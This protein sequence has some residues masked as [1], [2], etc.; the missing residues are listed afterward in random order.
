MV[1]NER[2]KVYLSFYKML[3]LILG[4]LFL[5]DKI[6]L[7]CLDKSHNKLTFSLWIPNRNRPFYSQQSWPNTGKICIGPALL[8]VY[9]PVLPSR[10]LWRGSSKNSLENTLCLKGYITRVVFKD[11]ICYLIENLLYFKGLK[12]IASISR[13]QGIQLSCFCWVFSLPTPSDQL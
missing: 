11:S 9:F 10:E 13:C 12:N 3:K 6:R 7:K 4:L 8:G 2:Y 5:L 1:T